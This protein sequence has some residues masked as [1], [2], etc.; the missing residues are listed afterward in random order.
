MLKAGQKNIV[1]DLKDVQ[2]LCATPRNDFFHGLRFKKSYFFRN[3]IWLCEKT[4]TF[5]YCFH[6]YPLGVASAAG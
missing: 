4:L 3:D 1:R 5:Y 6:Y 2:W